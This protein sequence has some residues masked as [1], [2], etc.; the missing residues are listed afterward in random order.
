VRSP[1][2]TLPLLGLLPVLPLALGWGAADRSRDRWVESMAR[3]FLA[4]PGE[5]AI[6]VSSFWD[7]L[8]SPALYLQSVAGVRPD[9]VLLDQ[10]HFRRTWYLPWVHETHPG[11]LT[12]LEAEEARFAEILARFET[13]RPYDRAEIQAAFEALLNAILAKGVAAGGAWVTQD[14]EAGVGRLW[15]RIPDGLLLRLEEP[16]AEARL[17]E[18]PP[19]PELPPL[20]VTGEWPDQARAYA[21]R[22]AALSGHT[23]LRLGEPEAARRDF[24]RA[25]GWNP[26]DPF[27]RD[28]MALLTR[29]PGAAGEGPT[30]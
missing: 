14:V 16:H 25:L 21:A 7:V 19:W 20:T 26:A 28:G 17:G 27:A 1:R 23:A 18:P 5:G 6:V 13:G 12:G 22:M 30:E 3:S 4:T 9:L 24:M 10:E 29:E 2:D 8:V 15:V 11:L